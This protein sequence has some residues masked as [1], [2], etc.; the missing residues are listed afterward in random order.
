[1][2][3]VI[4]ALRAIASNVS[5]CPDGLLSNIKNRGGEEVDELG[6]GLGIDHDL[7]MFS[8]SGGNIGKGP[9]CFKLMRNG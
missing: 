3:D 4:P 6:H 8:S 1:L 5:E 7:S 2:E 9:R